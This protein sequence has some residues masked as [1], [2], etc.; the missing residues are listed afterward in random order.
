MGKK[1]EGKESVGV[2]G[3]WKWVGVATQTETLD[4]HFQT[5]TSNK[6]PNQTH[7]IPRWEER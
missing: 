5:T 3:G 7:L 4:A 2:V 1:A 6:N